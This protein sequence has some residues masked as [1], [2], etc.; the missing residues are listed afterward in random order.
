MKARRFVIT[1]RVQGVGFRWYTMRKARSLGITGWVRNLRDGSV[2]V[3]AE[4][5]P[6]MLDA[7]ESDL[8]S[9][10]PG[11]MVRDVAAEESS[12]TGSHTG[13]EVRF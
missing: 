11:A 8:F 6:V 12:P 3:W 13:F 10:P 5:D 1:G 7:L 9:G 2:E 4:G